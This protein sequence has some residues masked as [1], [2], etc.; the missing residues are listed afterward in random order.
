MGSGFEAGAGGSGGLVLEKQPVFPHIL[1]EGRIQLTERLWKRCPWPQPLVL[2]TNPAVIP[3]IS[4]FRRPY[5][6]DLGNP[7][8]HRFFGIFLIMRHLGVGVDWTDSAGRLDS[9]LDLARD[10]FDLEI[11][12][13]RIVC[14]GSHESLWVQELL[15][16]AWLPEEAVQMYLASLKRRRE[17]AAALYDALS[18]MPCLEFHW[19]A[20]ALPHLRP[21]LE[22]DAFGDVA[23]QARLALAQAT[24]RG[25]LVRATPLLYTRPRPDE[26]WQPFSG[27]SR[28]ASGQGPFTTTSKLLDQYRRSQE[29][30]DAHECVLAKLLPDDGSR[31]NPCDSPIISS[32]QLLEAERAGIGAVLLDKQYGVI[33]RDYDLNTSSAPKVYAL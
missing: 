23:R 18:T 19:L 20:D 5:E 2:T 26:P 11:D 28:A 7:L 3:E 33:D 1:I 8:I 24:P 21:D 12:P 10:R 22:T 13:I 15:G 27:A 32:R 4:G 14:V 9:L 29:R 17:Y 31:L 25:E 16:R 30:K 6:D